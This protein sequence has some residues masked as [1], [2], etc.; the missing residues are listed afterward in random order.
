M[1]LNLNIEGFTFPELY[2]N[3]E[4]FN[5]DPNWLHGSEEGGVQRIEDDLFFII[6]PDGR[7][8]YF[9]SQGVIQNPNDL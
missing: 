9:N 4:E 3:L 5:I 8:V 2:T 6:L 1:N 7:T